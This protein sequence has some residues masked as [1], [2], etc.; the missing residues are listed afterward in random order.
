MTTSSRNAE[1]EP[2]STVACE[3]IVKNLLHLSDLYNPC[4]LLYP[5]SISIRQRPV[6]FLRELMRSQACDAYVRGYGLAKVRELYRAELQPDVIDRVL[7]SEESHKDYSTVL[8]TMIRKTA[9]T[10]DALVQSLHW[11][12]RTTFKV[13]LIVNERFRQR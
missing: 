1:V 12:A 4:P 9:T 7:A 6:V 10:H 5:C 2:N 3:L 13:G 8:H 11:P